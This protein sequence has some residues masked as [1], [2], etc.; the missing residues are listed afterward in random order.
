M[1]EVFVRLG[2]DSNPEC[3]VKYPSLDAPM[4]DWTRAIFFRE[5]IRGYQKETWHHLNGC[6]MW[7]EIERS[8]VTHE[9]KSV[10][11]C[12]PDLQKLLELKKWVQED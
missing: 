1:L 9:I 11:P 2:K 4:E 7:L 10:K 3:S 5:N 8:T 6:R 12:H